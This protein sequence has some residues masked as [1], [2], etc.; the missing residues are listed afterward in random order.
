TASATGAVANYFLNRRWT[1]QRR[2]RADFRKELVPY[3]ATVV[4]TALIAAAATGFVN[5]IVR[6]HTDNRS[7]RTLVNTV[8]FLAVYAVSFVVKYVVFDRLFGGGGPPAAQD[9]GTSSTGPESN[10]VRPS[11]LLRRS[12]RS[13]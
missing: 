11:R 8:T 4:I 1:W 2:G 3:W 12:S 9:G 5:A 13:Q 7:V 6:E 10:S